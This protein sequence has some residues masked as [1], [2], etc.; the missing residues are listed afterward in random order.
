MSLTF[1]FFL[2]AFRILSRTKNKTKMSRK[3][4]FK[5]QKYNQQN[6]RDPLRMKCARHCVCEWVTEKQKSTTTIKTIEMHSH[7]SFVDTDVFVNAE[8]ILLFFC[9]FL[10]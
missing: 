5:K 10:F 6:D 2:F 3:N 4:K 9:L 1:F 8:T 7:F